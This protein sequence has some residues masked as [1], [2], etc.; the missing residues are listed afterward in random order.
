MALT[1]E[2]HRVG[3]ADGERVSAVLA[4]AFH[5]DPEMVYA[6]PDE[7]TRARLLPWLIG[8]NVRYSLRYGE[9]YATPGWEG[10]ALWL[11]PGQTHFTLGHMLRA[12]MFA[13]PLVLGWSAL[14]RLAALGGRAV[15]L[16]Q[17]YAADPHWYLS[18]IG[19]EPAQQH[20]GAAS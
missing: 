6:L 19:V 14:R 10:A 5:D 7:E 11:P 15:D 2:I 12:G 18:Q 16:H 17:R 13:A 9:V 8:L 20:H 1:N 3:A 4:R